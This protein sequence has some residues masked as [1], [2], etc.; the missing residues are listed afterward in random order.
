[1]QRSLSETCRTRP[2]KG[3]R[4]MKRTDTHPIGKSLAHLVAD[5]LFSAPSF[6]VLS[7]LGPGELEAV[8]AERNAAWGQAQRDRGAGPHVQ[9]LAAL[10]F[11]LPWAEHPAHAFFAAVIERWKPSD[12]EAMIHNALR[13][14]TGEQA[15][16]ENTYIA[17]VLKGIGNPGQLGVL[18]LMDDGYTSDELFRIR[19]QLLRTYLLDPTSQA[20][21]R[22][23]LGLIRPLTT[24][25][26]YELLAC[27][28]RCQQGLAADL[29][30][31]NHTRLWI[32]VDKTERILDYPPAE[33]KMLVSG[34]T[35]ILAQVPQFLTL[36]INVAEPSPQLIEEVKQACGTPFWQRLDLDLTVQREQP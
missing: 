23:K 16:T 19:R 30:P 21:D 17:D 10:R 29:S 24:Q 36:W 5:S 3:K 9:D 32:T 35:S 34:L 31:D 6:F 27:V 13:Y 20:A 26:R 12:L 25:D 11:D 7:A 18:A 1:M 8:E 28:W 22:R 15:I 14:E 2:T 33:R 4:D